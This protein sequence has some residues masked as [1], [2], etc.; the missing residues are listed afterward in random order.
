MSKNIC[1]NCGGVI[2]GYPALSRKDNKTEIC[3]ECGVNEALNDWLSYKLIEK[4][5]KDY[6]EGT[7]IKLIHMNDEEANPIEDGTLGTVR[8]VDDI[9]TIHCDFDNGRSL[10]IIPG[11][12]A[13]TVIEE[14]NNE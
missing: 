1:P 10:G 8:F 2:N 4:W 9:G 5:K 12:D 3:S 7:R 13:F 11:V 14:V 6:P